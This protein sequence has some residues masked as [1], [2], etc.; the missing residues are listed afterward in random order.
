MYHNV[1]HR[2]ATWLIK[3]YMLYLFCEILCTYFGTCM[4][5]RM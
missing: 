3:R 1:I 2:R 4:Y 5:Q